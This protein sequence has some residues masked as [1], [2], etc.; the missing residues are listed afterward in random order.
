MSER[1]LASACIAAT[2]KARGSAILRDHER[3]ALAQMLAERVT[4]NY[5]ATR[6]RDSREVRAML[7][8]ID[9]ADRFPTL[10]ARAG[11]VERGE[12]GLQYLATAC[13]RLMRDSREWRDVAESYQTQAQ[14]Q[15]ETGAMVEPLET[16]APGRL[17]EASRRERD[18]RGV[19]SAIVERHWGEVA[20]RVAE[21]LALEVGGDLERDRES[22][23][24]AIL[25]GM[26]R[27]QAVADERGISL[28]LA[29][30]RAA[31]GS[32]LLRE[33]VRGSDLVE[34]VRDVAAPIL[35]RSLEALA[36]RLA[37]D[38]ATVAAMLCPVESAA[39][40]ATIAQAKAAY[41]PGASATVGN[42]NAQPASDRDRPGSLLAGGEL[43]GGST[44]SLADPITVSCDPLA[45]TDADRERWH[46][47]LTARAE[48][49]YMDAAYS[50]GWTGQ[51]IPLWAVRAMRESY[52]AS[53]SESERSQPVTD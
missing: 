25:A 17:A 6:A 47:S 29:K 41:R 10:T 35:S 24:V 3:E 5:S 50:F 40:A 37:S 36:V 19:D 33:N 7:R 49:M 14:R 27:L 39:I 12:S 32:T 4:R 34:L 31:R 38:P 51:A 21:S 16:L 44:D 43:R 18:A 30:K 46:R 1:E 28:S 42:A 20:E 53:D 13:E 8:Y 2:F 9:R 26:N 22:V 15:A 52:P 48:S 45:I 23:E 11:L